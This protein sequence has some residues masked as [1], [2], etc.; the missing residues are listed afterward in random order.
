MIDVKVKKTPIEY[1]VF[2]FMIY[3]FIFRDPLE[4][5][6][7]LFRYMDEM[8]ALLAIPFWIL[9]Y[10]QRDKLVFFKRKGVGKYI[11]IYIIVGLIGSIVYRYQLLLTCA[12][13]GMFLCMKFWLAIY[14]SQHVFKKIKIE[15]YAHRIY[16]HIFFITYFL[17]GL[18]II[19]GVCDCFPGSIRYGLKS[20]QLFYSHTTVLASNAAFLLSILL[21]IHQKKRSYGCMIALCGLMCVTLRSKAFGAVLLFVLLYVLIVGMKKPLKL[22]LLLMFVPLVIIAGWEMIYFYYLGPLQA[23]SARAQLLIKS[24]SVANDHFPFGAGFGTYGTYQSAEHYSPLYFM[25]NLDEIQG[26]TPTDSGYICDSFWP[27]ILA[28]SGW[29][30]LLV[31]II[32]IIMIYVRIQKYWRSNRAYYIAGIYILAYELIESTSAAAF[33]HPI[34][35][36]FAVLLGIILSRQEKYEYESINDKQILTSKRRI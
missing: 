21:M 28:E 11:L 30:G 5:L 18:V 15:E 10:L 22:K 19:D 8:F 24:I 14:T 32:A 2:I 4:K 29:I 26:L 6:S 13:P 3:F 1:Y 7:P 17:V 33:F 16:R 25:Y 35:I 34:A 9:D 36:Q 27:A 31:Y 12:L 20:F 23:E